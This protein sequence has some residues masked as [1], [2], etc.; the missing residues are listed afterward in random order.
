MLYFGKCFPVSLLPFLLLTMPPNAAGVQLDRPDAA[1]LSGAPGSEESKTSGGT[2]DEVSPRVPETVKPSFVKPLK[3]F[4][5]TSAFH[6]LVEDQ[7]DIWLG[8]TKI[9]RS[10]LPWLLPI[11][12]ATAA[13]VP[14]DRRVAEALPNSTT[15]IN[16]GLAVSQAGTFYALGGLSASFFLAGKF[17]GSGRARETGLLSAEALLQTQAVVQMM[18]FAFGRER[19]DYG[20]GQGRFWSGQ[21]SFPSGHAAGTW[22]VAAIISR[23]YY[24]NKLLRYGI[25]AFPAAVSAARIAADR[26][27]VSD[28]LAGALIG[29][30]IGAFIYRRHHDPALGGAPVEPRSR[31]IP[32][33]G[34]R[35]DPK[36]RTY[37]LS[38][39][40]QP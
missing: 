1:T 3:P 17:T 8:P 35:L 32:M 20:T 7:K 27:Y 26:H 29:N 19:P 28:V 16:A 37:A 21:Q 33:P 6:T 31:A 9:N 39:T 40:W 30:L 5:W 4:S 23:E 11:V 12:G 13:M 24:D 15:R 25:Y 2:V 14:F 18:K 36:S 34:V 10:Q 22:A 38:L